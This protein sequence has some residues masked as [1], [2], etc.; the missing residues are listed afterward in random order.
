MFT[1]DDNGVISANIRE[2]EHGVKPW[3]RYAVPVV[4]PHG[5]DAYRNITAS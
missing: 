4:M 3:Q 2:E 1:V 5:C